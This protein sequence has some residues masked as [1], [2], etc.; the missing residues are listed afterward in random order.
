MVIFSE[1]YDESAVAD[2]ALLPPCLEL[3][4][5]NS[6]REKAIAQKPFIRV[7]IFNFYSRK[8]VFPSFWPVF[9]LVPP[10]KPSHHR[11]TVVNH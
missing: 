5:L 1:K 6:R 2:D 10:L 8:L 4:A 11:V 7:I 9:W 3:Q